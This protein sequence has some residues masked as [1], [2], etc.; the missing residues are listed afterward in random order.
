[1]SGFG[2]SVPIGLSTL[3]YAPSVSAGPTSSMIVG[4]A[5]APT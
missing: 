3:K 1:M 4:A 5:H 2:G